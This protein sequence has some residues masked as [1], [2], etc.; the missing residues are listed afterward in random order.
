MKHLKITSV[1]MSV[2]M[3]AS[4]VMTPVSVIADDS[5]ASA[6]TQT[7]ETTEKYEPEETEKPEH[8]ETVKETQKETENSKPAETEDQKDEEPDE[9]EP[10]AVDE[11][12]SEGE[13]SSEADDAKAIASGKCGNKLKWSLDDAGTLK[14]TGTGAMKNYG[15]LSSNNIAPWTDRCSEIKTIIVA[16]G[17]T[18]IG[19]YA[20]MKC[21]NLTSVSL[22]SGLKSVGYASFMR[23]YELT[24]LVIPQSVTNIGGA[25]FFECKKLRDVNIPNKLTSIGVSA[26]SYCNLDTVI[27]PKT[28]KVISQYAFDGNPITKLT[29]SSGVTRIDG[30]A[31]FGSDIS[32]VS[33]PDSVTSIG[34][35]AFA[36]SRSLRRVT[37]PSGLKTIG[38]RAFRDCS[39]LTEI[40]IPGSVKKI[41]TETFNGCTKL[42][43]VKIPIVGLT[44]IEYH[45]F[46]KC[47]SLKSFDIPLTVVSLK[48]R[49]FE[50][51]TQ[52][53]KVRI[54]K[55]LN[56]NRPD[57]VFMGCNNLDLEEY[58]YL[59][60]GE[61]IDKGDFT[62][63]VTYPAIDGSGTVSLKWI[64]PAL[65]QA[66]IPAVIEHEDSHVIYKVTKIERG[67]LEAGSALKKLTIGS[68]VLVISDYAFSGSSNLVSVTGGARLKSIGTRAFEKCPKLKVFQITSN[69]FSKI[70]P[71]S[72]SGDKALKTLY[73]KKTTKLTK[74]GVK[75]SLKGSSVKTVKVKKS[76][77]KK[78]KK[79]FK[80]SN[81]GKKVKV[82]K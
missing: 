68:N 48:T 67:V 27:I 35:L 9:K 74:S 52:L 77:I 37:L 36:N 71:F 65:D 7:A 76:K 21:I 62:F 42:S 56:S 14:I 63:V 43:E 33:I 41:E 57:G 53:G 1:L 44:A 26:F 49:A 60:A 40:S 5:D 6:E 24:E 50:D 10:E 46:L 30:S 4:M 15:S 19:S 8:K 28:L 22:P 38:D 64:N 58:P 18:T 25:A 17:V 34:R 69:M 45:A 80:K 73:L 75:K 59:T 55:T 32:E 3:C 82:K 12:G 72:F 81:S 23:C 78:Y 20:F 54:S 79:F 66:V 39:E 29:I 47:T 16:K 11:P 2:V 51:C 31:F 13:D 70:G 61:C